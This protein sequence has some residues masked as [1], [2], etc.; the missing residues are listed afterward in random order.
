[1]EFGPKNLNKDGLLGPNSIMVVYMEPLGLSG[2][3]V[4]RQ[5]GNHKEGAGI[6]GLGVGEACEKLGMLF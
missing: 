3:L 5:Q 4:V 2:A 1:M 6:R